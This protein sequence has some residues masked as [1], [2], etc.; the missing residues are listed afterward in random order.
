MKEEIDTEAQERDDIREKADRNPPVVT[1]EDIEEERRSEE[2]AARQD[3]LPD[4]KRSERPQA[5]APAADTEPTRL[6]EG[7]RMT[8]LKR[9][10]TDI[11]AQ[12]VDDPRDAVKS[13]DSLVDDVI[14]DLSTLFSDERSKLESQWGKNEEVSTEDLRVA[15]RRYRTFFERLLSV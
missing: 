10:W 1:R 15:L 13:A 11:Q 4:R 6:F 7:D 8:E 5:S 3:P 2:E 14:R 9:R 12:F